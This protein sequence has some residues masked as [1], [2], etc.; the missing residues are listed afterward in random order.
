MWLLQDRDHRDEPTR[1]NF[2]EFGSLAVSRENKLPGLSSLAP[3][4]S[5][6]V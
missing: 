3:T 5:L 1:Q 4:A 6:T 2:T